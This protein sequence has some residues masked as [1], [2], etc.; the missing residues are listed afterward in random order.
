MNYKINLVIA[1]CIMT[2]LSAC[3]KKEDFDFDKL[4]KIKYD[5]TFA[6]PLLD[7]K[8][9]PDKI[10]NRLD[11]LHQIYTDQDGIISFITQI[12]SSTIVGGDLYSIDNQSA[13]SSVYFSDPV[14]A[15][16][17]AAPTGST[18]VDSMEINWDWSFADL[19]L[20]SILFKSGNLSINSN[21]NFPVPV[22]ATFRFPTWFAG[23]N[24]ISVNNTINPSSSASTNRELAGTRAILTDGVS[25]NRMRVVVRLSIT[26][27]N[28]SNIARAN[29]VGFQLGM[30]NAGFERIHGYFGQ[31]N[32]QIDE[33]RLSLGLFES[34][35][36]GSVTF[37]N[38][39][40][41][42]YF[43]NYY[44]I[45]VNVHTI[46]PF[47]GLD[48]QDNP[49]QIS[50]LS[51]P[52][53]FEKPDKPYEFKR[54]TIE[55][56]GGNSNIISLLEIPIRKID[57][58]ANTTINPGG[59]ITKN[60][61]TS[62]SRIDLTVELEVPFHGRASNFSIRVIEPFNIPGEFDQLEYLEL[63]LIVENMY[64]IDMGFQIYFLDSVDAVVDSLFSNYSDINI[65]K[66]ASLKAS[67]FSDNPGMK[68]TEVRLDKTK[69]KKLAENK[70][71]RVEIYAK[72]ATHQQGTVP[73]KVSPN[74]YFHFKA[75]I[76]TKL[77]TQL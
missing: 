27:T 61:A 34:F 22:T 59:R 10:L 57:F 37:E 18:F 14:I 25:F 47:T 38:P 76:K 48:N 64:A 50:G 45:P 23:S 71:N 69:L 44:G 6:V 17:N 21:S 24:Q 75:G 16:Y 51:P 28:T 55:L 60:F 70:V 15:A 40:L 41:R 42:L 35:D 3:M 12:T 11:S 33:A 9:T 1:L 56:A 67:G 5:P 46:S 39:K 72:A 49:Y 32:L 8:I 53:L 65:V 62:Q 58:G 30:Q 2:A 20:D 68:T 36:D 73:I 26:K 74:D 43:D 31:T 29:N 63:K 52:Y 19:E 66:S 54:S 7:V 77:D 13:S 4:K